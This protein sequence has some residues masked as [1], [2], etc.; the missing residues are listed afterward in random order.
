MTEKKRKQ[1]FMIETTG[2]KPLQLFPQDVLYNALFNRVAINR[3]N[4]K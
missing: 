2:R 1:E 4:K 3:H